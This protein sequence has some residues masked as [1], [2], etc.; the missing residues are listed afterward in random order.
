MLL[1]S[2]DILDLFDLFDLFDLLRGLVLRQQA[3]EVVKD[4]VYH[5]K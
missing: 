1:I 4:I 5:G 3:Q 2:I